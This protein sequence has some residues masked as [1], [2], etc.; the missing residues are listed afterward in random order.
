[1]WISLDVFRLGLESLELNRIWCVSGALSYGFGIHQQTRGVLDRAA[2]PTAMQSV[3]KK[4]TSFTDY[5]TT[6]FSCE[7]TDDLDNWSNDIFAY[8]MG[9][10]CRDTH[11]MIV[12][13]VR[14]QGLSLQGA[15][16]YL[17]QLCEGA[18]QCFQD[19][20]AILPHGEKSLKCTWLS[21]SRG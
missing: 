17:C 12:V 16:D 3:M 11:N 9:Q 13:L 18:I 19:D 10:S 5:Y 8:N 7:A 2:E 4:E 6:A 21:T 15:V 14:K 1:M 20:H